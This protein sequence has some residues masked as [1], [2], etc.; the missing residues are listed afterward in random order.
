[1]KLFKD[2]VI[3]EFMKMWIFFL[4][5]VLIGATWAIYRFEELMK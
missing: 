3:Q 1:M 2:K 5:G 4:L